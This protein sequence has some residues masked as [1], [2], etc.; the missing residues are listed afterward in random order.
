MSSTTS[1]FKNR[2]GASKIIVRRPRRI[3]N[4]FKVA[5]KVGINRQKAILSG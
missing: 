2:P 5:D 1:L 3:Q 4:L